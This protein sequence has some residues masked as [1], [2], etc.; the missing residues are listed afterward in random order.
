MR[1]NLRS[2]SVKRKMHK[3]GEVCGTLGMQWRTQRVLGMLVNV[4]VK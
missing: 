3:L 4:C 1:T 2:N